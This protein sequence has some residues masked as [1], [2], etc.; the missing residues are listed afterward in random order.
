MPFFQLPEASTRRQLLSSCVPWPNIHRPW[1]RPANLAQSSHLH[2]RNVFLRIL[3]LEWY[4]IDTGTKVQ[5]KQQIIKNYQY[6]YISIYNIFGIPLSPPFGYIIVSYTGCVLKTLGGTWGVK[7]VVDSGAM[8]SL[9]LCLEEF[10][11]SRGRRNSESGSFQPKMNMGTCNMD[12]PKK[13]TPFFNLFPRGLLFT[14]SMLNLRGVLCIWINCSDQKFLSF[15]GETRSN[16]KKARDLC[17]L[18]NCKLGQFDQPY[19]PVILGG[20]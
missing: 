14:S 4:P 8:E 2:Q 7:A 9:V 17:T 18:Y 10:W 3:L 20:V 11:T 19:L 6:I 12:T 13:N 16:F 5:K 1:R 15:Q